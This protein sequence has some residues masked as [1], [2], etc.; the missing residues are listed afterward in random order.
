MSSSSS[1]SEE[2]SHPSP[3]DRPPPD[4]AQDAAQQAAPDRAMMEEVLKRTLSE[5]ASSL[6]ATERDALLTVVRRHRG[7]AFDVD[8]VAVDLVE[9]LLRCEFK[10]P[11]CSTELWRRMCYEIAKTLF[12]DPVA[13]QR[14]QGIWTALCNSER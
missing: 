9:V 2:P 10:N 3:K 4:A 7:E 12:D 6:D 13:R 1:G 8:P 14:M 5:S 11:V